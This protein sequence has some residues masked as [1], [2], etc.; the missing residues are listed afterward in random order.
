MKQKNVPRTGKLLAIQDSL[1]QAVYDTYVVVGEIA[2]IT[3]T[4]QKRGAIKLKSEVSQVLTKKQIRTVLLENSIEASVI[5]NKKVVELQ[6]FEDLT[7]A[8][9]GDKVEFTDNLLSATV[10]PGLLGEIYD[11]NQSRLSEQLKTGEF[12]ERGNH[13]PS[14]DEEKL[15]DFTPLVKVGDK[16]SGGAT[17]GWVPEYKIQHKIF[18]PF[19]ITDDLTIESIVEKSERNVVETIATA[20]D[21]S[22]QKREFVMSFKW[23]VKI[24]IP[25]VKRTIPTQPFST[26]VRILD[27]QHPI[28]HGGTAGCPGGFGTGKTV[29]LQGIFKNANVDILIGGF[30]GERANEIVEVLKE[31]TALIDI[32]GNPLKERMCLFANTSSMPVVSREASV[33]ISLTVGEYYRRQ[34]LKVAVMV[35]SFSRF[36]QAR[37][38]QS[39]KRGDIPGEESFPMNI[40]EEIRAIFNR[41][42]CDQVNDK[43]TGALTFIATVSPAGAN[44]SEPI[45]RA[46]KTT[47]GAFWALDRSLSERSW[48]PAVRRTDISFSKYEGFIPADIRKAVHKSLEIRQDVADSIALE[49]EEKVDLSLFVDYHKGLLLEFFL[50]QQDAFCELKIDNQTSSERLKVMYEVSMQIINADL[51]FPTHKSANKYFQGLLRQLK[52]WNR[53]KFETDGFEEMKQKIEQT[54]KD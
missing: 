29:I 33:Y 36:A 46:I 2:W 9:V 52:S 14:L 8:K 51:S 31:Y 23:S 15:W 4:D 25:Y 30:C 45:T 7:D 41:P 26:G 48:Y 10:G 13:F 12:M 35:D 28:M 50:M 5:E 39:G 43:E 11:G 1:V 34:G 54:L 47:T 18:V 6:V 44:L 42:G 17:L 22:G 24:P 49:G 3:I 40:K 37:R 38:E 32:Y 21:E 16:V 53:E 19:D 20:I 27:G